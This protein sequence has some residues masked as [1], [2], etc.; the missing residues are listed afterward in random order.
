MPP[1]RARW[2][3]DHDNGQ[4][5]VTAS[6]HTS[7]TFDA[8]GTLRPQYEHVPH[9]RMD[10]AR[11]ALEW[12]C[13]YCDVSDPAAAHPPR[14]CAHHCAAPQ[15]KRSNCKPDDDAT[16]PRLYGDMN[17]SMVTSTATTAA[18]VTNVACAFS[19]SLAH[20]PPQGVPCV[21]G[22]RT[23]A[24]RL[25]KGVNRVT[26]KGTQH[27]RRTRAITRTTIATSITTRARAC[28]LSHSPPG[29]YRFDGAR[30]TALRPLKN[31][32]STYVSD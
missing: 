5:N 23:T 19:L 16:T 25:D 29:V 26:K 7:T 17:T 31:L 27:R 2:E 6:M 18:K 24:M 13:E 9:L 32:P 22:A 1:L 20:T 15:Q 10:S 28:I 30:I 21:D 12:D 11:F 14:R 8:M 4:R 3:H